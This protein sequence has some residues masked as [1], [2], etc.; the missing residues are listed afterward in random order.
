MG[1]FQRRRATDASE[2]LARQNESQ[3]Q[4]DLDATNA[5]AE[6]PSSSE[7]ENQSDNTEKNDENPTAKVVVRAKRRRIV[8]AKSENPEA[9]E[10][11]ADSAPES[12]SAAAASEAGSENSSVT[13]SAAPSQ[14]SA[15]PNAASAAADY[16]PDVPVREKNKWA[17]QCLNFPAEENFHATEIIIEIPKPAMQKFVQPRL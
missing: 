4:L 11:A 10:T 9:G 2:D 6:A 15:M 17:V 14:D 1:P 8:K 5:S 12:E 13:A 7:S 16:V 3:P